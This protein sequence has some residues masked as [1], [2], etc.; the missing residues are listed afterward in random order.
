MNKRI[1]VFIG[2]IALWPAVMPALAADVFN[3]PSGQVSLDFVDVE[4]PGNESDTLV[5][6]DGTTGYGAVAYSYRMG[7]YEVTAAQYVAFLNAVAQTD[8][9]GLYCP[10]MGLS[11]SIGCGIERHG[12]AGSYS[13][14]VAPDRANRPVNYVSYGNALRFANWLTNGQPTGL[15]G[16]D[17][18]ESGSYY[19]NGVTDNDSL[20]AVTRSANA[21]YV[22]PTEDEWYKAAY[23]KNDGAT[24]NYWLYPTQSNDVPLREAPPGS[25]EPPGSANYK[26]VIGAP[27][28]LTEAGAY[29]DSP[30]AYGTYD[31]GG[32]VWE[33]N[34][35][36]IAGTTYRGTRGGSFLSNNGN[37]MAADARYGFSPIREYNFIGFRVAELVVPEPTTVVLIGT[38]LTGLLL[39]KKAGK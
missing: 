29:V 5:M 22:V 10:S 23:H 27:Y 31:Q 12:E 19:L 11:G 34:E 33:W 15:Q 32:N 4:N 16:L 21:H 36:T 30:S 6:R 37:L 7:K 20:L 35:A 17:T 38:G 1:Q 26:E 25:T 28:Y 18:T 2:I 14:S 8:T 9:Y 3:M 39:R 24:G 13:Y